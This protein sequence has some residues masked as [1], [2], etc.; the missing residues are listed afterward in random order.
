MPRLTITTAKNRIFQPFSLSGPDNFL[1][2][3]V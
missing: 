2:K 3:I 1:V